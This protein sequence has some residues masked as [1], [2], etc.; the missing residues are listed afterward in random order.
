MQRLLLEGAVSHRV[1]SLKLELVDCQS[2]GVLQLLDLLHL[3]VVA[4]DL[5]SDDHLH[6]PAARPKMLLSRFIHGTHF[7]RS[8]IISVD[9]R[10]CF[11]NVLHAEQRVGAVWAAKDAR[12]EHYGQ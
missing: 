7:Q 3:L 6:T 9:L 4:S 1:L 5:L 2:F 12:G 8:C 10:G 11:G